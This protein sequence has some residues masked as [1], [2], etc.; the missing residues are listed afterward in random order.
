MDREKIAKL[1]DQGNKLIEQGNSRGARDLCR[2]EMERGLLAQDEKWPILYY[3]ADCCR[4]LDEIDE[5]AKYAWQAINLPKG[6]PIMTQQQQLS[7]HLFGL[8]Y[9]A[10]TTDE[11]LREKSFLYDCFA[12]VAKKSLPLAHSL[13]RHRHKRLRIGYLSPSF[14]EGVTSYFLIQLFAI[15]DRKN[16]EVY[17]YS[18][19]SRQD[20][21][22]ASMQEWGVAIRFFKEGMEPHEMAQ[23]IYDDEIDILFDT[24]VHCLGGRTMQVMNYRPAPVQLAGI[25]YMSTSG[26]R[27]VD[28]FLGDPYCDPPEADGDFA[29]QL[30][31]MPYS[32]FCYTPSIRAVRVQRPYHV[33]EPLVFGSFN[34]YHKMTVEHL[35]LWREILQRV[36]GSRLLI[37]SS[38]NEPQYEENLRRKL[39]KAGIDMARVDIDQAGIDYLERYHD[40]DI[41]LDT[42]PYTGGGT[43]C[44]ALYMGV[45]VIS[46]YG[47][48]HGTRFGYS[49]LVNAG[50]GELAAPDAAGYVMRAVQLAND[51]GLLQALHVQVPQ[52][53]RQTPLMDARGYVH[54]LEMLYERIWQKWLEQQS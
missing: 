17:A 7:N 52:M 18:L 44:D 45:P 34:N 14:C 46:R 48:R 47:R 9:L 24:N 13:K 12:A 50:L 27:A 32:H 21:V 8:H 10:S 26:S 31:R 6:Q 2:Q 35:R 15:Y 43:T 20:N 11:E 4:G 33:H 39:E 40:V 5:A 22:T 3:L 29:E 25:G 36:S 41:A 16:F 42:Y 53:I 30:L 38:L 19:D 37:K 49:I 51:R 54:S 23:A 1:I 28:Y